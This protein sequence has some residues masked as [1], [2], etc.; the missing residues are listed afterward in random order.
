MQTQRPQQER[1]GTF[2]AASAETNRCLSHQNA[3]HPQPKPESEHIMKSVCVRTRIRRCPVRIETA[4]VWRCEIALDDR[5]CRSSSLLVC[6]VCFSHLNQILYLMHTAAHRMLYKDKFR[7]PF[8]W[9]SRDCHRAQSISGEE[10]SILQHSTSISTQP[11]IWEEE[12]RQKK[13]KKKKTEQHLCRR[14]SWKR[15]VRQEWQ[16]LRVAQLQ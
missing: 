8:P 11:Q 10:R 12:A 5:V 4:A 15:G 13:K 14:S 6:V 9:C 2:L 3:G 7:S 1:L 16:S